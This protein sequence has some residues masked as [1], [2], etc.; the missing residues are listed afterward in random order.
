MTPESKIIKRKLNVLS[1]MTGKNKLQTL[2]FALD[3]A[4][5]FKRTTLTMEK[6]ERAIKSGLEHLN[7]IKYLIKK[8][9]ELL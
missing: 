2:N 5:A 7:S 8:S 9:K 6:L 3:V 1:E 4:L